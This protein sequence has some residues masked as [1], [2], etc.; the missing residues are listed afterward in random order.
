MLF[1][2]T[3]KTILIAL[4]FITS[5]NR[6]EAQDLISSDLIGSISEAELEASY[7]LDFPNGVDLYRVLYTTPDVLG[8]LDT[9]SGL[10]VIPDDPSFVY[11]M[12]V[13]QH[14]TVNSRWD[15]PSQLAGGYQLAAIFGG[16]GYATI[17]PDFVGLGE[18]RGLHPYV[19][20]DTEASA[21]V[22]F[23]YAARQF[24]DQNNSLQVNDQVFVTGYSQGGHA[25]LAAHRAMELEYSDDFTVTASAPMSGPYSVSQKMIDFTLSETPYGFVSYIAWTALSYNLAYGNLFSNVDEFFKP[26]YAPFVEQFRDEAITLGELNLALTTELI[27]DVG[28]VTPKD[29]LQPDILDAILN[30][31]S[32]PVSV[33]LAD[34]DLHGWVPQ[35]PTRLVYCTADDQVYYQNATFADSIMNA[36]GASDLSAHDV[37]ST[38]DHGGCVE[39]ATIFTILFFNGLKEVT[40]ATNE[41]TGSLDDP[42]LVAPNPA[43]D[44]LLIQ[45]SDMVDFNTKIT[46]YD[47]QGQLVRNQNWSSTNVLR[48]DVADLNTGLYILLIDAEDGMRYSKK[49]LVER[50]N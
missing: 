28:T 10:L 34:N 42:F 45:S 49:V 3:I 14:G 39:P 31:P 23:L 32:H 41:L 40:V 20:A 44:E 36:N 7:I 8:V 17:A 6:A 50:S 43:K 5:F 46:M 9:A 4:F 25:A 35:A 2:Q 38:A 37:N 29:M 26:N 15:V 24:A 27:N 18:A 19:H 33:A 1:N 47:M 22:D 30:D 12:L 21:A 13:F 11:P 48:V 16:Q